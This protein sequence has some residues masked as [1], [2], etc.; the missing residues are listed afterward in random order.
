MIEWE[1]DE[2][3][4]SL[5]AG[6]LYSAVISDVLDDA[7]YR[8]QV[9]SHKI[10]PLYEN[11]V[12]VGRAM[13]VL[14]MDVYEPPDQPYRMEIEAVDSL[15]PNEILVCTTNGSNRY[16]FWGELL[17]T[18]SVARGAS[19]AIID[20]FVRDCKAIMDME[21]PVF[22][23]GISPLDS[24]GRGD[25][26]SFN[27]PIE[28]GGVRVVSGDIAFGDYDGIVVVPKQIEEQIVSA[29]F[30]KVSGENNIR[31]E[32]EAGA[33]VKYVFDKYGIL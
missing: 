7:G 1:N 20:G 29:A 32:L 15:K 11:V 10:R 14:C 24:K 22:A 16:S 23:T 17:S 21:F 5:M 13:T 33:T 31:Q 4:F 8:N 3:L 18:A 27:I 2:Q 25:V 19:G 30:D 12:A 26:V 6:K 9:M 28:C